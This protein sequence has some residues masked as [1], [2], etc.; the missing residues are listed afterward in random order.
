[1]KS[2]KNFNEIKENFLFK[3]KAKPKKSRRNDVH[4]ELIE[5]FEE[6]KK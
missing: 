4:L 5:S 3:T 2:K 1:M 6:E